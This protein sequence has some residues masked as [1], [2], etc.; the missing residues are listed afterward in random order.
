ME[1]F[2]NWYAQ[3]ESSVVEGFLRFLSFPSISTDPAH[4]G[5]LRTTALWLAELLTKIGMTVSLWE[6]SNHP[7]LFA[8]RKSSD[9]TATTLLIYHHYDVQPVDPLELWQ[10]PPFVPRIDRGRVYARG[11]Q[12]NKGQCWYTLMALTA[13]LEQVK[14]P[15]LHIKLIIEGAEEIG[16]GS[17]AQILSQHADE[18]KTDALLVVDMGIPAP[19]QPAV[20]LGMRGLTSLEMICENSCGDLHSGSHGG[21][22]LNPLR[23]LTQMLGQLW[24]GNGRVVVP[25]FYRGVK[26]PTAAERAALD[27][28]FDL[29]EYKK[30]FEIGAVAPEQPF[31]ARESNWLRPTLEINGLSGGYT[32]PGF[33]TV[34][35]AR[36]EAKIS[37][38][39]VPGQDP[40]EVQGA[41][42][43]HLE[44]I[45]P[46]GLRLQF[47]RH[48]GAS[49]FRSLL[50]SKLVQLAAR[51]FE[52]I[53]GGRCK[54]ELCGASVP[55]VAQ[56]AE[57][58]AA[59]ETALIGLG[60]PTDQIHA[61]N[62]H[63]D[64]ERVR[65]GYL[66]L[67]RIL[68]SMAS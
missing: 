54:F 16:S 48:H 65:Q 46:K 21:M 45:A 24:D 14:D 5:D 20:T 57:V 58:S 9:P 10:S 36:A 8:E 17:T 49:A 40:E 39:L 38:R 33:K 30:E 35:P 44:A 27:L 41:I 68:S 34:I 62:E 19:H 23:A 29:E 59:A 13:F 7:V 43:S 12:D 25:G 2:A 56:L 53:M 18:L 1:P 55:I 28:S 3:N 42:I 37:A 61:P 15:K 6:T 51:S 64:L 67:C 31:S 26:E 66:I 4:A 47:T 32:G 50:E 60:L 63:F 52:E 11:A 22:I